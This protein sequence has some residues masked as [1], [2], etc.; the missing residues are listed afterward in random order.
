MH[1]P[2]DVIRLLGHRFDFS[3][4]QILLARNPESATP[5]RQKPSGCAAEIKVPARPDN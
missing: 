1:T 4:L 2:A 5:E 3:F